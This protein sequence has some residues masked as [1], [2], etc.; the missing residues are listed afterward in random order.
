MNNLKIKTIKGIS[1]SIIDRASKLFLMLATTSILARLLKPEEFGIVAMI[2]V[3]TGF[4]KV[5]R[6][7][8]VGASVI[9]RTDPKKEELDSLFWFSVFLGLCVTIILIIF[10]SKIADFYNLPELENMIYV[11]SI[12]MFLG[13]ISIIPEA[14]LMKD[15]KFKSLFFRN[16]GNLILSGFITI[17]M[18]LNGFGAWSLIFKEI[19]FNFFLIIFNFSLI[20]WRPALRFKYISIKPYISYSIPLFGENSLNYFVRNIDNLLIGK[21]LGESSLGFYSKA[22]SLM[23]LPVRQISGAISSVIFP[24]LSI[25]KDDIN[26]VWNSYM[27]VVKIVLIVNLPFMISLYFFANE[28]VLILFGNQWLD[29]IPIIKALCFLGSIQSIGTLSGSIY[30]SQGKTHLQFKVGLFSKIVMSSGIIYGLLSSGIF[31]LIFYYTLTSVFIFFVELFFITKILNNS[32][33]NFF[34]FLKDEIFVIVIYLLTMIIL[35]NIYNPSNFLDKFIIQ[36][37]SLIILI[38]SSLKFDLLVTKMFKDYL[39]K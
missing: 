1:W 34:N 10:S 28:V 27:K 12:A 2:F 35:F 19:V 21:I 30:N 18:A 23:L 22:Y 14:L 37:V 25:I 38:L 32:I 16:S 11:V 33:F 39:N 6:D 15:L 4:L 29:V 26:K 24:S 36:S 20:K 31:G 9:Q 13:S 3:F 17:I 8:G 7:F 5:I